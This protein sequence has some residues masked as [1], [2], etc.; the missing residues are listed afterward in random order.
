[1]AVNE[2]VIYRAGISRALNMDLTINDKFIQRIQADGIIAVSYTHLD[3]Y[4]RQGLNCL[5]FKLCISFSILSSILTSLFNFVHILVL[6]LK[7]RNV[8]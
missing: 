8:I 5:S 3:V 4:K 2:A 1:M 6:Y 7:Q